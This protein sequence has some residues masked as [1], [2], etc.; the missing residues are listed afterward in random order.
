MMYIV[1]SVVRDVF[2]KDYWGE[3]DEGLDEM[4][5]FIVEWKR[6]NRFKSDDVLKVMIL[7]FWL[8]GFC[9]YFLMI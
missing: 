3:V 9:C 4:R 8:D 1:G 7:Y 5:V 2:E 6:K